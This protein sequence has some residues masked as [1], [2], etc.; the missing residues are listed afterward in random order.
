MWELFKLFQSIFQRKEKPSATEVRQAEIL[1]LE[2]WVFELTLFTK[3]YSTQYQK[4]FTIQH[5][6]FI[7][8]E[9]EKYSL[10]EIALLLD[11]LYKGQLTEL[12]FNFWVCTANKNRDIGINGNLSVPITQVGK[13]FLT[14]SQ[15][16]IQQREEKLKLLGI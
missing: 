7:I 12:T 16:L 15:Y 1:A 4:W 9:R 13:T 3:L 2:D 11:T 10:V 8:K 5:L 6:P 14:E